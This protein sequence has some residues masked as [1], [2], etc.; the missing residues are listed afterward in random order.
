MTAGAA[1]RLGNNFSE[2]SLP[3]PELSDPSMST[4]VL[5]RQE[6]GEEEDDNDNDDADDDEEGDRYSA[7]HV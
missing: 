3:Y 4:D 6:P 1:I 2:G 5:L 7:L